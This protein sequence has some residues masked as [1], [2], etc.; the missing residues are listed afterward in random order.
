M[1]TT[2]NGYLTTRGDRFI[3]PDGNAI[4]LRGTSLGGWLSMENFITGFASTEKLMRTE[5]RKVLG[6]ELADR[7]F[8]GLL[9]SFF[10]EDDARLLAETSLNSVRIPVHYRLFE[11]D[12]RPFRLKPEG[13]RELDRAIEACGR[14]GL[15]TII[16]LHAAPGGQNQRWHSDNPT[17]RALFWEYPHFQD[18]VVHLW[19]G[20]ADHYRDWTF[21]AGYNLLNEPGDESRAVVAPF[22]SRLVAA[23]RAVDSRHILFLDGNTYATEFDCFGDAWANAVYVCHDYAPPGL[24]PGGPYPGET[25]GAWFDKAALEEKFLQRSAHA[26]KLGMPIWVGEFGPIYTGDPAVDKQR[27]QVLTDQ[28]GIYR[29]HGASWAIWTYKDLG[30]QGLAVVSPQSPYGSLVRAFV[31]KKIRLGADN[32]GSTGEEVPEVTRPVQDLI[33]KEFPQ[34]DPYPWGRWDWVRLLLQQILIAEPLAQEYAEL[35]RG[36]DEAGIDA[37]S[38]SFELA[39]CSIRE[40][41]RSQLA[42]G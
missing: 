31:D 1:D 19:E 4:R 41:L 29:D 8:R 39:A 40:P 16:D 26:R 36:L 25:R 11:D 34:F 37:L 38:R 13:F 7:F 30:R 20:L 10:T 6:E 42:N 28:L 33:A 32:W 18:R 15:Y 23:V 2:A 9:S 17:H 35:F 14:R 12:D 21:V 3:G 5:L 27:S 22:Y 24:G